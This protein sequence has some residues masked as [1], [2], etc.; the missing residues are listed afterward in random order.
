[1]SELEGSLVKVGGARGKSKR[2]A[3][4][5]DGQEAQRKERD[6]TYRGRLGMLRGAR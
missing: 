1:M 4:S 2:F 3:I 6:N 5:N